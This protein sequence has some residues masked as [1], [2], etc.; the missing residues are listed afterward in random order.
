MADERDPQGGG[1]EDRLP[2]V[3][4]V[5]RLDAALDRLV[6]E[7]R[8]AASALGPDERR[9]Q[10]LAAQM[11]LARDG[12]EAPRAAFLEA[13]EAAVAREARRR[14]ARPAVSRGRF[15]RTAATLAGGAGLGVAAVEGAAMVEDRA[16][17]HELVAAG[18]GRWYRIAAAGEVPPGG[19]KLFSAGGLLGVL[20]NSE[21]RL[22]AV[23]AICTHMGCR[24]KPSLSTQAPVELRCLCH[25]SRFDARGQ[26]IH[27]L[28]PSPLPAIEV[29]VEGGHVYAL[30][31][32]DTV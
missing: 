14:P 13:L 7:R 16:R 1:R 32:T 15:L 8:P 11:R 25:G 17:P 27:G 26:V 31:T 9:A 19:S 20:L 28:A 10:M 30:G 3:E 21:G 12:V 23:S 4:Q 24:L 6:D 22:H 18:E 2:S 5:A 29:R